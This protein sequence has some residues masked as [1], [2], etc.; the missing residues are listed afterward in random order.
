ME[1]LK[2]KGKLGLL[3]MLSGVWLM[4]VSSCSTDMIP[5]DSMGGIKTRSATEGVEMQRMVFHSRPELKRSFMAAGNDGNSITRAGGQELSDGSRPFVS[6]YDRRK[7]EAVASLNPEQ[8]AAYEKNPEGLSFIHFD[9]IV[10]DERLA[11][12]LNADAEIQMG[13]T[14]YRYCRAGVAYAMSAASTELQK[15]DSL[16][17]AHP[18]AANATAPT[19]L[20]DALTFIPIVRTMSDNDTTK[21]GEAGGNNGFG[22]G[23]SPM[24]NGNQNSKDPVE[25]EPDKPWPDDGTAPP[26][27]PDPSGPSWGEGDVSPGTYPFVFQYYPCYLR[28]RGSNEPDFL[29]ILR[30]SPE[31][32]DVAVVGFSDIASIQTTWAS[33][34]WADATLD[35]IGAIKEVCVK[36]YFPGMSGVYLR[37]SMYYA[38]WV[39]CKDFGVR[40]DL[41]N[42]NGTSLSVSSGGVCVGWDVLSFDQKF[43][44]DIE[45]RNPFKNLEPCMPNSAKIIYSYTPSIT[46]SATRTSVSDFNRSAGLAL[47]NSYD[48]A[49]GKSITP[50]TNEEYSEYLNHDVHAIYSIDGDRLITTFGPES[51]YAMSVSNYQYSFDGLYVHSILN[52]GFDYD[53]ALYYMPAG[54]PAVQSSKCDA[55]VVYAVGV[56]N[57]EN[58]GARIILTPN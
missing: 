14:V 35:K 45:I 57:G 42:E 29:K 56:L 26:P 9:P 47:R 46:F 1:K 31:E 37:L 4:L 39:L 2:F 5:E 43:T 16:L 58:V 30:P 44:D 55:A 32:E 25:D 18:E 20:G 6:Y 36:K 24:D 22:P 38:D 12:L 10:N 50:L 13:D 51:T 33:S 53:G 52:F 27:N 7:A 21:S 34:A 54:M 41:M 40:A 17:R 48:A 11:R 3:I 8:K 23:S 19:Q 28:G 49:R 15:L